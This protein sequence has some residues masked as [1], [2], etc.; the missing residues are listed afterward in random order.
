MPVAT[1]RRFLAAAAFLALTASAAA[2]AAGGWII[3][4]P[5]ESVRAGASFSL[6]AVRP[7]A[8]TAWPETLRLRLRDGRGRVALLDLVAAPAADAAADVAAAP[9]RK[10]YRGIL[11]SGLGGL[12][13]ADLADLASNRL[14]LL[15]SGEPEDAIV[16]MRAAPEA[17]GTES[18]A[19]PDA[20][21]MPAAEARLHL[22]PLP[23]DEPA[24]SANEPV[25]F[26]A[27][28]RGGLN[29]R[30]QLSF[31]YRLFDAQGAPARL[32]PALGRLH[33]GYTQTSLWDL[34]AESKPFRDTSYRPSLFWQGR[35]A[36]SGERSWLPHTLRGGY[37][38]ES[39]GKDGSSSRSIDMLFLQ[40]AWRA[41][42][43]G[44]NTLL[45]APK[46]YT[47][48]DREDN[49]DIARYRGHTD[50]MLRFG[51]ERGW[52]LSSRLRRGT[53]GYAGG[54]IDLSVPLRE[55]LF[56]RTGG[57]LHFQVISGYGE[58]LLDYNVKRPAQW[59]IGFSIVR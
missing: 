18:A 17:S 16:G 49:P 39:N 55:P 38:H 20:M 43:A 19:A 10:T 58:S 25:Y 33:F 44:G 4:T 41:D 23:E 3:A 59:R 32:F 11:P 46:F 29:A 30:F 56:A 52:L 2:Q 12:L 24:L 47:Y 15:A 42:F 9:A 37:E 21:P 31:K 26:V 5:L 1:A 35:I 54:Q 13:R 34:A 51:D 6:E 22:D 48:L 36:E 40:P 45:F 57:F 7:D 14:A 53:A 8:Q 27:G 50:W 28:S